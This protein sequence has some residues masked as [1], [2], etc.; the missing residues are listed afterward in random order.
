MKIHGLGDWE[1]DLDQLE[2]SA[3]EAARPQSVSLAELM[4]DA[5]VRKHSAFATLQAL[6]EASGVEELDEETQAGDAWNTFIAQCTTFLNWQEMVSTAG[7]E[8]P[9]A[10]LFKGVQGG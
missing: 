8:H 10:R 5:F 2:R 4:P 3:E 7:A 6:V 9:Q 1:R